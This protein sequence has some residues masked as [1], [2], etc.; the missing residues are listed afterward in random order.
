MHIQGPNVPDFQQNIER[1]FG[2]TIDSIRIIK[3]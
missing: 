1:R 3:L 2:M